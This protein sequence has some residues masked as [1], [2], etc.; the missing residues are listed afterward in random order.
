MIGW[1]AA[2]AICLLGV[3]SITRRL[4]T[5]LRFGPIVIL[6]V[7]LTTVVAYDQFMIFRSRQ[8]IR[9]YVYNSETVDYVPEDL[10]LNTNYRGWCGNGYFEAIAETY[11]DTAMEG[12]ESEDPSVRLRS[13]K[14]SRRVA[15]LS[16]APQ[17]PAM[18]RRALNDSDFAVREY[19][20]DYFVMR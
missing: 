7:A 15:S 8:L 17:F 2:E 20:C 13:L 11:I 9:D 4:L 10:R 19:A 18:M 12:F 5:H 3:K 16:E 14:M 6:F 1:F